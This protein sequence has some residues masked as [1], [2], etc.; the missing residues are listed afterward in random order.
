ML[1]TRFCDLF[2]IELPIIC[3]PMGPDITSPELAAAVSNA[4]GLG[5]ISFGAY[6]PPALRALIN[7]MRELTDKPF[8]INFILHF[9]VE[10]AFTVC[11]EER[12]P[13][14]SF[15]WGDPSP[16]VER[17]HDA[18]LKVI[19]QVGSVTAA[20]RSARAGV[21]A[22]IA[23][24][25]EAGGHIAGTVST[26]ALVPRVVD[27]VAPTPVAAAGGIADA[28]GLVAGLALGADAVVMGT[29]LLASIEAAAHPIYKQK[30]LEATEEDTVRTTLFGGGWPNAHHRALRTKFV[31]EWLNDESRGSEQRPDEPV[32]G[33]SNLGGHRIP[34]T[35]FMSLPPSSS[36]SGD[37][38]SMAMLAGQGVGLVHE[39]K[40]A[41]EIIREIAEGA[42]QIIE[43]R[44]D[45]ALKD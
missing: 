33:E 31:E 17:A 30:V 5:L 16:Y 24:G 6:P 2:G 23:Q 9:P 43:S 14:L 44:L 12:V 22:I 40:P 7:R 35:R 11:I 19:E 26:M 1:R 20:V 39:I 38:E 32:I 18:G 3:A 37:I 29:R 41:A 28:R 21:D 25:N 10:E 42:R 36:A 45:V 27:A 13:V 15:F 4:G 8:G 34:V